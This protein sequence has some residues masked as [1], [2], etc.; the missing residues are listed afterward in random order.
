[1]SRIKVVPPVEASRT[2]AEQYS[3]MRDVDGRLANILTVQS[4]NPAAL[5]AHYD[6]YRTVMFGASAGNQKP[7][8]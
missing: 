1:M 2:L 3:R 5:G 6:L 7:F 4:L 8:F